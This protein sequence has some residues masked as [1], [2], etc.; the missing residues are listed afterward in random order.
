M[1]SGKTPALMPRQVRAM[2]DAPDNDTLVGLRDRAILHVYFYTGGRCSDP[3]SL[4]VRDFRQ[5]GEYT[6][7]Q[8]EQL[9]LPLWG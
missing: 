6:V 8:A 5:D 2:L 9:D 1:G 3:G 4:K 7:A